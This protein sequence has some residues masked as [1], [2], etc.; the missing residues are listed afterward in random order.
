M[1]PEE[2]LFFTVLAS[3]GISKEEYE[4]MPP[5]EQSR[6]TRKVQENIKERA[7]KGIQTQI[8]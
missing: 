8:A 2:R 5:E 4:A 6:I 7:K 1:S 3:M